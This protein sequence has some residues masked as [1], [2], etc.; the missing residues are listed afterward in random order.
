MN[1]LF[2]VFVAFLALVMVGTVAL[3]LGQGTLGWG[4]WWVVPLAGGIILA[5]LG[6]RLLLQRALERQDA[7]DRRLDAL[8]Q[9]A[10]RHLPGRGRL[11]R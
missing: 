1:R 5:V 4:W 3:A 9:D 7:E 8:E 2:G 6:F 10:D 11:P